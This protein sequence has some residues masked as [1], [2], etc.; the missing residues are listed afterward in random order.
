M[1]LRHLRNKKGVALSIQTFLENL[2]LI[3]IVGLMVWITLNS[4]ASMNFLVDERRDEEYSMLLSYVLISSPILAEGEMS[5]VQVGVLSEEKINNIFSPFPFNLIP[6]KIDVGYPNTIAIVG[7]VDE[8]ACNAGKCNAW[9]GIFSDSDF[10][11]SPF[12]GFISCVASS[13]ASRL[14]HLSID[15]FLQIFPDIYSCAINNF[16]MIKITL[17][18]PSSKGIPI[19]IK[20]KNGEMHFG[21]IY[22]RVM[23][24]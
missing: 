2:I 13:I 14:S 18:L 15:F 7:I 16:G 9:L 10:T 12:F 3:G 6:K 19:V 24:I 17:S 5:S 8:Q 22:V 20:Y 23:R 1:K 11:L 4:L 21:K